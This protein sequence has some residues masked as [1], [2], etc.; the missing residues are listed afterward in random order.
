V[1]A[2]CTADKVWVW[3]G[4]WVGGWLW[5][6]GCV[7]V[8][9]CVCGAGAVAVAVAVV[10]VSWG[11]QNAHRRCTRKATPPPPAQHTHTH[12]P[13]PPQIFVR[14]ESGRVLYW[15]VASLPSHRARALVTACICPVW[16]GGWKIGRAGV[17]G[18]E[19]GRDCCWGWDS[20]AARAI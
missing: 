17:I 11:L 9:V 18:S 1:Q 10:V 6:C 12:T 3:V 8:C 19:E 7:R 5:L 2:A 16:G 20:R 15:P 4:G 14:T 13:P